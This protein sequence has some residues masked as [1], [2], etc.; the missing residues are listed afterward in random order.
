DPSAVRITGLPENCEACKG[1]LLALVRDEEKITVPLAVHQRL[2]G[3]S[4]SL[5]RRVRNEFDVQVD[6]ARV[7]RAPAR[8]ID[9]SDDGEDRDVVYRDADADLAGL[10]AEWILRGEKSK[11]AKALEVI[12]KEVA[13]PGQSV[14]ARLR[15]EPRYHRHIIGKQGSNISKIRDATGC[16][17]TVPKRGTDSSW[18]TISGDRAGVERAIEL[19]HEAVEES[20]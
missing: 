19:I 14:E 5:W 18:V 17:V 11:L 3:R 20:N 9:E 6:A 1:A 13:A 12:N 2:G 10:T 16:E 8:R 15:V 4:G 7:D